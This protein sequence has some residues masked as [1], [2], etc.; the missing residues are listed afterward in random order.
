MQV[1]SL[2]QLLFYASSYTVVLDA[3][4]QLAFKNKAHARII[5]DCSWT[6]DD[7]MFATGSRDKTVKIWAQADGE[8]KNVA[9]I[10]FEEAITA[11]EFAPA[12][13]DGR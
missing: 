5:W 1:R 6:H 12:L 11:V 2:S 8:W 10:K 9:T 3:P 4:Y 7:R 13:M